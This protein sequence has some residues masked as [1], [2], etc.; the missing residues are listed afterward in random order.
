LAVTGGIGR[1]DFLFTGVDFDLFA[2]GL[3]NAADEFGPHTSASVA[4]YYLGMGLTW[5][6]GA[7]ASCCRGCE[8]QAS[9]K[10]CLR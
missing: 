8:G 2:G 4:V 5:R 6:Y 9:E 3:F 7:S 1:Q 10:H